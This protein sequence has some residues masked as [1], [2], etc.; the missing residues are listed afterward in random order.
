M[1]L[2]KPDWLWSQYLISQFNIT[3]SQNCLSLTARRLISR[4]NCD[5]ILPFPVPGR[6]PSPPPRW[7]LSGLYAEFK[8]GPESAPPDFLTGMTTFWSP[9]PRPPAIPAKTRFLFDTQLFKNVA[10]ILGSL[11]V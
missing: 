5:F 6:S 2:F 8:F 7:I 10:Y 11:S 3:L 9:R 1:S 4:K